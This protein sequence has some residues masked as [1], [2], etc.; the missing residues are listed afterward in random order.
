MPWISRSK[1][2]NFA[3][4]C[5]D[6]RS[7]LSSDGPEEANSERSKY[8]EHKYYPDVDIAVW[9]STH[10]PYS[11]KT[12][13]MR[14]LIVQSSCGAAMLYMHWLAFAQTRHLSGYST[15][16]QSQ[17]RFSYQAFGPANFHACI[18]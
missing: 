11:L 18:G 5:G 2:T 9:G 10:L 17:E 15:M 6:G 1:S 3:A 8:H 16:N 13:I 14:I 12:I 4:C 7:P